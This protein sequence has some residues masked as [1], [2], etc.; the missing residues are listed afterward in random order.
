VDQHPTYW[1]GDYGRISGADKMKTEIYAR[2]PIGCGMDV[3]SEFEKYTGGIFSQEKLFVLINHEVSVSYYT[4]Y[5]E[6]FA[7]RKIMLILPSA[8]IGDFFFSL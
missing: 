2:G 1:V 3:T 8:L 4:L 5:A 6:I 7:W